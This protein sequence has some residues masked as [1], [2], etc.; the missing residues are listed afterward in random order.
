MGP[1][2]RVDTAKTRAGEIMAGAKAL[3]SNGGADGEDT[4][5][6]VAEPEQAPAG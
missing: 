1:G 2:I 5:S 4:S 6:D 3:S